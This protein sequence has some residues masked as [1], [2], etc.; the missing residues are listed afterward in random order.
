MKKFVVGLVLFAASTVF[1]AQTQKK[2]YPPMAATHTWVLTITP[3]TPKVYMDSVVN[4]W[5]NDSIDLRFSRLEY[6]GQYKLVRVKGTVCIKTKGSQASEKFDYTNLKSCK[7][8]VDN[9]PKVSIKEN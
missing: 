6:N 8:M 1:L 5:R 3:E 2:T 7:I 9:S 4:A